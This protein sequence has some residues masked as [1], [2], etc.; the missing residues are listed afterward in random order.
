MYVLFLIISSEKN[1]T[2]VQI[3]YSTPLTCT[4]YSTLR[5]LTTNLPFEKP[6][7]SLV[8]LSFMSIPS[9][10]CYNDLT[11][12]LGI[13]LNNFETLIKIFCALSTLINVYITGPPHIFSSWKGCLCSDYNV[14]FS[15]SGPKYS[16]QNQL[17]P[18]IMNVEKTK[19]S[20]QS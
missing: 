3:S 9:S 16:A 15:I 14:F 18:I 13:F 8:S 5:H 10:D 2:A 17:G 6:S 19:F 11:V 20:F 7:K 4:K 12:L 1:K